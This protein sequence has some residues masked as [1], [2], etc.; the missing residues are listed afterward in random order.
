MSVFQGTSL[1]SLVVSH[2][3]TVSCPVPGFTQSCKV[4]R[5]IENNAASEVG[6]KSLGYFIRSNNRPTSTCL[7]FGTKEPSVA[8][9]LS[10]AT[11]Y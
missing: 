2:Q 4:P 10:G 9:H 6:Q 8:W 7:P 3:G 5:E 11:S 1:L